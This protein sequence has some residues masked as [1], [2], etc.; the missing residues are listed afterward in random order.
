MNAPT[1]TP[2]TAHAGPSIRA[3]S[4]RL[5]AAFAVMGMLY[6]WAFFQR[7]CIGTIFDDLQDKPLSLTAVQVTRLGTI[8]LAI[9]APM[10]LI[11]GF[12]ADR[13]GGGRVI[14]LGG[15]FLAIGAIAFPFS[16]SVT[17]LYLAEACIGLGASVM[18]ICAAREISDRFGDRGFTYLFGPLLFM[19]GVGAMLATAPFQR[20][21]HAFGWRDAMLCVG[22]VTAVC[23][24]A[25]TLL[26]R[27]GHHERGPSRPFHP[28]DLLTVAGNP[29]TLPGLL[30]GP[31]SFTVYLVIQATIGKKCLQDL[32]GLQPSAASNVTFAM[33][34]LSMSIALMGG[35]VSRVTRHRRKPIVLLFGALT[36]VACALLLQAA[37]S[38]QSAAVCLT[39]AYLLL[40]CANGLTPILSC[41]FKELSH[42][43]HIGLAIG[44]GNMVTYFSVAIANDLVGR[45]LDHYKPAVHAAT[46][47][48]SAIVYP[49]AAY[50]TIFVGCIVFA[51]GCFTAGCFV[52]ETNGRTYLK[53][54]PADTAH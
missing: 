8:Y 29:L 15:V 16:K 40:A 13:F 36:I 44:F 23:L 4:P 41:S 54:E 47:P 22:I 53:D 24:V 31:L 49:P 28:R 30:V 32:A 26:S 52:K 37:R 18:F 39:A 25:F 1:D 43:R 38:P 17:T 35:L 10:Q 9:Y 5:L 2:P 11:S 19:G 46:Q 7:V 6:T 50:G 3:A 12:L 42:P 20:A 48:D 34:V 33:S 21:V 27:G 14:S 51:I 45:V